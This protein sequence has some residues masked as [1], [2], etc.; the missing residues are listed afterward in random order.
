M[1]EI[2]LAAAGG[3]NFACLRSPLLDLKLDFAK[4]KSIHMNA[5]KSLTGVIRS[6][7]TL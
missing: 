3:L 5:D 1:A 4:S 2:I 7:Y 6:K